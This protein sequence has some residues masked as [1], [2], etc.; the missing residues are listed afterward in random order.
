MLCG[1]RVL[2]K[3]FISMY[4]RRILTRLNDRIYDSGSELYEFKPEI[5]VPFHS[6]HKVLTK[7]HKLKSRQHS[8][9]AWP[10]GTSSLFYTKLKV[11]FRD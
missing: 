1:E 5:I 7:Y 3:A 11:L 6:T 8:R 10:N 9:W 2:N 4:G